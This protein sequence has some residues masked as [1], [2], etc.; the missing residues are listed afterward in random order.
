MTIVDYVLA[1]ALLLL[2]PGEA[3]FHSL[4]RT[5]RAPR[6]LAARMIRTMR[7]VGVLLLLLGII[8]WWEGRPL[9]ALGFD[10]PLSTGGLIGLAIAAV[11]L[12]LLAL[13]ALMARQGQPIVNRPGR[14]DV[15]PKTPAETRIYV[16]FAFTA[17]IG[18]EILYRGFLLWALTPLV[19]LWG[20]VVIAAI[21]YGL[22]HASRKLGSLAGAIISS[23]LFTIG[24]ALTGSLWWLILVHVGLPLAGLLT[25][26]ANRSA[27]AIS[28]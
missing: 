28:G 20:A 12:A 19:G 14:A 23:F 10:L 26:R 6:P 21:A 24:Y 9:A 2:L 4:S 16:A 22:A 27:Q 5:P 1:A 11:L 7:M 25:M 17:G 3:L 13:P 8:W 15:L 18:W